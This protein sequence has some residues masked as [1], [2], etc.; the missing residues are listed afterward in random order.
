[1]I[2]DIRYFWI[3]EKDDLKSE[4]VGIQLTS[5]EFKENL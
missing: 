5:E 3:E 4:V 2:Y 1:M